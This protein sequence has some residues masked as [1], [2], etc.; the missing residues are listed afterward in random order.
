MIEPY[1]NTRSTELLVVVGGKGK[2]EMACPHLGRQSHDS[3]GNKE[4]KH[5][6]RS[7]QYQRISA[8]LSVGDVFIN[9]AGHPISIVS[10]GNENLKLVVFGV[11][12]RRNYK[13]FL[14]GKF[15]MKLQKPI[16]RG[17]EN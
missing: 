15:Q 16:A 8:R 2:V 3:N 4:K 12:A 9:P 14:A 1:H 5:E 11:N 6:K 13:H 10:S 7:V 17:S